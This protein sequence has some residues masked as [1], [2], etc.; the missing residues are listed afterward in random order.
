M[1]YLRLDSKNTYQT[2]TSLH[3]IQIA[4]S[5]PINNFV[6]LQDK[7]VPCETYSWRIFAKIKSTLESRHAFPPICWNQS[8]L[9]KPIQTNLSTELYQIYWA[10][11]GYK[12]YYPPVPPPSP[13]PQQVPNI[14]LLPP[15]DRRKLVHSDIY[16]K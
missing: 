7:T 4:T 1:A 12:P 15:E 8:M 13:S 16:L 9:G 11:V 3:V 6:S 2:I 10:S 14:F 5:A